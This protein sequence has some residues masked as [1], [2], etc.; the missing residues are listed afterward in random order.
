MPKLY[1]EALSI[2]FTTTITGVTIELAIV[3]AAFQF[4]GT[5]AIGNKYNVN[6]PNWNPIA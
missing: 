5:A 2:S 3:T 4:H 6:K 1:T